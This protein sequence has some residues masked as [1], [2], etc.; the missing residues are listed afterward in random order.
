MVIDAD[1]ILLVAFAS[2]IVIEADGILLVAFAI[3]IVIDAEDVFII[4][5]LNNGI[6]WE[7]GVVIPDAF[8][9]IIELVGG[10][11]TELNIG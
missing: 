7:A 11:L 5:L 3:G 6:V 2:G 9:E 1:D 10:K 4:L 8:I